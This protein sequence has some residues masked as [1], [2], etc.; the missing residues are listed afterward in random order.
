MDFCLLRLPELHQLRIYRVAKV[1][2]LRLLVLAQ[3]PAARISRP[4]YFLLTDL[5]D[6]HGL[7]TARNISATDLN[8]RR[9][10]SRSAR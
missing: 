1:L 3:L 7:A 6:C 5:V 8:F 2:T 9:R 4:C 10:R